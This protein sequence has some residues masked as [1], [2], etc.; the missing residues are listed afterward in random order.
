[1]SSSFNITESAP[2]L[3]LKKQVDTLKRAL[4]EK[5]TGYDKLKAEVMSLR[6]S[7]ANGKIDK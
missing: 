1:M 4:L 2:Y 7:A 6:S 3:K 5:S